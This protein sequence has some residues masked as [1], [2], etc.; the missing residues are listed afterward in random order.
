MKTEENDV[1]LFKHI[2]KHIALVTL[3]RPEKYNAV[4]EGLSNRLFQILTRIEEDK[5]LWATVLTSSNNKVFCA[6]ADLSEVAAGRGQGISHPQGGFAGLVEAKR[7]KPWIAAV[8]GKALGGGCEICLACDMVVCGQS[9]VFGL[10]EVKRS[11]IAGAGGLYRLPRAIPRAIAIEMITTGKTVDAQRAAHLGLVNRVAPDDEVRDEA[12]RLAGEICENA[13][14]AVFESLY[15]ARAAK[16]LGED[17]CRSLVMQAFG[18]LQKTKD[19]QEG[20]KAFL[21]KRS[22]QWMGE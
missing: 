11:I 16:E 17:Q 22:P 2:G 18:R 10:P 20:P 8:N 3:N 19:F 14:N 4:N 21:E 15:I 12:I 5:D 6:G 13:P 1:V 9:A 7:R